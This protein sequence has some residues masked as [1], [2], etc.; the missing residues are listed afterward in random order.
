[1][2]SYLKTVAIGLDDLAAAIFLCR[3]DLTISAACGL[4]R[5]GAGGPLGLGN[6]RLGILR[7]IG[8]A[9]ELFF[10]GHC[11]AAIVHDQCRAQSTLKILI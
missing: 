3:N 4:V 5:S 11:A 10:P 7:R 9:L 8:S 1:M 6:I 2:S